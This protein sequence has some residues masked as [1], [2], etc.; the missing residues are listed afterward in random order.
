[1][2]GAR[3]RYSLPA[4]VVY[5]VALYSRMSPR[6]SRSSKYSF[7]STKLV[8]VLYTSFVFL[9]PLLATFSMSAMM[10]SLPARALRKS[11]LDIRSLFC[12]TSSN[13]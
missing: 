1:M 12:N 9:L 2:G 7:I 11:G 3:S 6:F 8:L 5:T 13:S 4:S 10:S